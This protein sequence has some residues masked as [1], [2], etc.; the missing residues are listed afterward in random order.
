MVQS[1]KYYK[2]HAVGVTSEVGL[3]TDW[4]QETQCLLFFR[5]TGSHVVWATIQ[6]Y[7]CLASDIVVNKLGRVGFQK[8]HAGWKFYWEKCRS[9][10]GVDL[11]SGWWKL[12][13]SHSWCQ[14]RHLKF[15]ENII[16]QRKPEII[17]LY[18]E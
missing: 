17:S 5:D 1:N 12:F 2:S 3:T 18:M 15:W 14:R 13:V 7:V 4:D 10:C 16:Y 11:M 9:L 8:L 6:Q